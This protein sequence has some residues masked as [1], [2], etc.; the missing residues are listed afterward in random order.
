MDRMHFSSEPGIHPKSIE[1]LDWFDNLIWLVQLVNVSTKHT[2]SG[3]K[4]K[5]TVKAI[6]FRFSSQEKRIHYWGALLIEES[7]G[8]KKVCGYKS[9]QRD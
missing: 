1:Q 2:L 6:S 7:K 4:K 5:K 9:G 8:N 3:G